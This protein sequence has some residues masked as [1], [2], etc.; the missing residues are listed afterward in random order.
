MTLSP[1]NDCCTYLVPRSAAPRRSMNAALVYSARK[2][3]WLLNA[4]LSVLALVTRSSN[5][6]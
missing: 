3:N 6:T 4:R 2:S 5:G 1:S